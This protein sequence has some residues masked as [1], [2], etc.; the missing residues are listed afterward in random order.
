MLLSQLPMSCP[1]AFRIL[2]FPIP[3][4][5]GNAIRDGVA[6]PVPV[7]F[8]SRKSR[9]CSHHWLCWLG[10]PLLF[11]LNDSL[12]FNC[13]PGARVLCLCVRRWFRFM[14]IIGMESICSERQP[15]LRSSI[16]SS[17]VIFTLHRR[18]VAVHLAYARVAKGQGPTNFH[19]S[20]QRTEC[21]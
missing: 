18:R 14:K 9:T 1:N 5:N 13:L 7:H 10:C 11:A 4:L 20:C 21:S 8:L 2:R 15:F 17:V 12:T 3:K 16:G 6:V 19:D